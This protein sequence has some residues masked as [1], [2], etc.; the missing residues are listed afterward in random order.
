MVR[1]RNLQSEFRFLEEFEHM[2]TTKRLDYQ[3]FTRM[4]EIPNSHFDHT[5]YFAD[6]AEDQC[7]LQERKNEENYYKQL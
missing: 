6:F 5:N 2:S 3:T 4:I 1:S 7:R